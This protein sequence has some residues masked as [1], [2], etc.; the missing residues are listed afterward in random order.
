MNGMIDKGVLEHIPRDQFETMWPRNK[1]PKKC[2]T[3]MVLTVKENG[4]IK[5]RLVAKGFRQRAGENYFQTFSPVVDRTSVNTLINI[6][7][8]KGLPL[9]PLT[10]PKGFY[11][12]RSTKMCTSHTTVK[13]TNLRKRLTGRNK[14]QGCGTKK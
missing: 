9:I 1:A 5:A 13:F 2:E 12:H 3:R 4:E 8:I 10:S 6:A 7:A 14:L 11:K